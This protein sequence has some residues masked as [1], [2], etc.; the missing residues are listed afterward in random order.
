MQHMITFNLSFNSLININDMKVYLIAIINILLFAGCT[1]SDSFGERPL[2]QDPIEIDI[3]ND[4]TADFKTEFVQPYFSG[5]DEVRLTGF[6][7]NFVGYGQNQILQNEEEN[8][9][10]LRDL[11]KIEES[12]VEPLFWTNISSPVRIISITTNSEGEWPT[13]WDINSDTEHSSYFLGLKIIVDNDFQ[14]GW[15]EIEINTDNGLVSIVDK[16]IL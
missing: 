9:L 5:P 12:V 14:L 8:Y 11:E 10:F 1:K 2:I 6:V 3:D 7:G 16:G 15:V 13:E 4:G